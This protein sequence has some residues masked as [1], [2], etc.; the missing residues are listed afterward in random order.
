MNTLAIAGI[1]AGATINSI[2]VNFNINED[3]DG[4]LIIN[5]KAPSNKVLNFW[6]PARRLF[7]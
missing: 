4:D 6:F 3:L 1:P 7:W 5:L 2:T